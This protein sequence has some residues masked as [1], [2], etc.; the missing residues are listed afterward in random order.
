MNAC[1]ICSQLF[2]DTN[3]I[4]SH[5]LKSFQPLPCHKNAVGI[6]PYMDRVRLLILKAKA[7]NDYLCLLKITALFL[8]AKLTQKR[9]SWAN[10]VMP[11]PSSLWSR[12]NGK[13]DI[14]WTLAEACSAHYPC[15]FKAPPFSLRFRFKKQAKKERRDAINL[16]RWQ[17][18]SIPERPNLLI[19]DDVTTSGQTLNRMAQILSPSYNLQFLSFSS[20]RNS[21]C[22]ESTEIT[23]FSQ[24]RI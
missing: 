23:T 15:K 24:T 19:I 1:L 21:H 8:E 10:F 13:S 2:L 5:C 6:Y 3:S 20:A 18:V 22:P 11:A 14:S 17:S 9:A 7:R 16:L 12:I 4:C